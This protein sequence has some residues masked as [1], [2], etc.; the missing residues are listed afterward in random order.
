[1]LSAFMLIQH[2]RP[3]SGGHDPGQVSAARRV[4][5]VCGPDHHAARP[6]RPIARRVVSRRYRKVRTS[7]RLMIWVRPRRPPAIGP[8]SRLPPVFLGRWP[9]HLLPIRAWP[10]RCTEVEGWRGDT[11]IPLG[12]R[13]SHIGADAR[14]KTTCS[15]T[16]SGAGWLNT[17]PP[18]DRATD[19]AFVTCSTAPRHKCET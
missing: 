18:T 4:I 2:G 1:M 8:R 5:A 7:S 16:C 9:M 15:A 6:R 14:P 12:Y 10:D 17:R 11:A 13:L 19:G 3:F